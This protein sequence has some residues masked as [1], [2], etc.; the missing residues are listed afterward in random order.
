MSRFEEGKAYRVTSDR[1]ELTWLEPAGSWAWSPRRAALRQGEHIVFRGWR[2]GWGSDSVPEARFATEDGRASGAFGPSS[3]GSPAEGSL[4]ELGLWAHREDGRFC[5]HPA[6]EE[7][8]AYQAEELPEGC[9][10]DEVAGVP[11]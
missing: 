5:I 3:W 11:R 10:L 1:A 2:D 4:E 6:D 9:K 8:P 7:E